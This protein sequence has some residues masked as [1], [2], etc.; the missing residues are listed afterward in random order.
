L[1]FDTNALSAF[2]DGETGAVERAESAR[3]VALP[4]IVLGEFRFGIGGSRH[5]NK[6]DLWLSDLVRAVRILGVVT[7]TTRHYAEIRAELKKA[8]TPLPA[9]DV[10]IAALCRQHA[11]PILSRDQHFDSVRGV[12]RVNW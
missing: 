12:E 5:R 6:Y 11:L 1:I 3:L 10:W 9:N 8:G 2:A 4:V 7:E